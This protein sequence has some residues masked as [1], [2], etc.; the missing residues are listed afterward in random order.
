M[1]FS[2]QEIMETV[3]CEVEQLA[4]KTLSDPDAP[5]FESGYLDSLNILHIIV[6]LESRF[7]L[8]IDPFAVNLEVLGTVAKIVEF[9]RKNSQ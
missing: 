6:F 7:G 3:T 9:V 5:L 1:S 8:N 2:Q 4:G